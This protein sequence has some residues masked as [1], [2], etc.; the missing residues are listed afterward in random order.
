MKTQA[1][2]RRVR[3][4]LVFF[5]VSLVVSGL[6]AVPIRW[7]LEILQGFIG[8]GTFMESLWPAVAQW[9]SFVHRGLVA[10]DQQYPFMFYGMDWLAFA[11]IVIAIAFW[12]PLRD[13]VKHL[14]IIEWG[15]IACVLVIPL[16]LVCGP[17]RGIPF[18]HQ[19]I[20]C[21]FGVV[22]IIPLWLAR[23]YV[24]QIIAL[25]QDSKEGKS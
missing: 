8:E 21:S 7:E 5:V 11:H 1:L 22:G 9:I 23:R 10:T 4:L 17:L 12:G 25:G 6:T 19:L 13:P 18:F 2:E 20:D 3:V 16:A 14:W 15:M 24:K